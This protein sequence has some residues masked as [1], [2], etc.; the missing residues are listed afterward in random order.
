[1]TNRVYHW[2]VH[3]A[4]D[5]LMVDLQKRCDTETVPYKLIRLFDK[6][7]CLKMRYEAQKEK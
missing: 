6:Y 3:Q 2:Q 5:E 7:T 1:M 4:L